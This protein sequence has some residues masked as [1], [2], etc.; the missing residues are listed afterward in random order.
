ML[1]WLVLTGSQFAHAFAKELVRLCSVSLK[2]ALSDS[3]ANGIQLE[4]AFSL[5]KVGLIFFVS[6]DRFKSVENRVYRGVSFFLDHASVHN[7]AI[8]H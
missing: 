3:C 8:N 7:C 5:K 6:N 1:V 2:P 4:T